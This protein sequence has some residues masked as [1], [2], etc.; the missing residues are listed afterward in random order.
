M[1]GHGS[2]NM[3]RWVNQ[4]RV[5]RRNTSAV[6]RALL[7]VSLVVGALMMTAAIESPAHAWLG[8]LALVPLFLVIRRSRPTVAALGGTLWGLTIFAFSV[9][10][11]TPVITPTIQ[12]LVS[13][14]AIPAIYTGLGA[15]I[16]RWI[17]FNP[18]ILGLTWVGVELGLAPMGLPMGMLAGAPG[19][20]TLVQWLGNAFG[21]VIIAFLVAS[22][23]ATFVSVVSSALVSFP[24]RCLRVVAP[25]R[26]AVL[27]P[28]TFLCFPLF[29]VH[30]PRP[31]APPILCL[32]L[33]TAATG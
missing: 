7:T 14:T 31:R 1:A 27:S 4:H 32:V 20:G 22:A 2:D 21:Y 24:R 6:N 15:S 25:D 23:G 17:G 10:Q 29:T 12:S 13:L 19:D 26:G 11:P 9:N 33:S 18:F 30:A 16:T 8:W 3:V 5:S 28:Q